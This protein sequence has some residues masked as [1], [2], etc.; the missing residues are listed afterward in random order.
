MFLLADKVYMLQIGFT[1]LRGQGSHFLVFIF[2]LNSSKVGP[3]FML[4]GIK[5][6]N[7]GPLKEIVSVPKF[8]VFLVEVESS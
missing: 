1:H 8:T 6:H 2:F 4:P 3:D 7:C 5:F